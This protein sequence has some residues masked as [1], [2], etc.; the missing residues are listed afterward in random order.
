MPTPGLSLVGFMPKEQAI[1][2]LREACVALDNSDAALEAEWHAARARLGDP[3][4]RAGQPEVLDLPPEAGKH[5]QAVSAGWPDFFAQS[6]SPEFRWIEIA[7]LL[8]YQFLVDGPRSDQ[9]CGPLAN[10]PTLDELLTT[11]LP[12]APTEESIQS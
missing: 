3:I 10:P 8:A 5:M 11:A 7:P 9:H 1:K 6:P 12:V 2:H 4:A